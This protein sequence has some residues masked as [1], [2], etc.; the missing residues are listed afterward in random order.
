MCLMYS[1]DFKKLEEKQKLGAGKELCWNMNPILVDILTTNTP[2]K[3][4]VMP[5]MRCLNRTIRIPLLAFWDL[6]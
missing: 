3:M 6:Y 1:E 4:T 5:T 2:I